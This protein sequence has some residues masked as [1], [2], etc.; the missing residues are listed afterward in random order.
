MEAE[1]RKSIRDILGPIDC[2]EEYSCSEPEVEQYGSDHE[3]LFVV[4]LKSDPT[5]CA[6]AVGRNGAH[7]CRC[8]LRA[9][10]V[11]KLH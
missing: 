2:P 5:D 3:G 11:H 1:R 8:V 7:E 10:L 4:C 6:M 9:T